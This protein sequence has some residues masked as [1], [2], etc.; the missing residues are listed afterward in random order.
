MRRSQDRPECTVIAG[1]NGSGKSTLARG[2]LPTL[3][4]WLP[5]LITINPDDIAHREFKNR[6]YEAVILRAAQQAEAMREDALR[7]G[8]HLLFET[9]FSAGD[10]LD[11]LRRAK[12][13]GYFVRLIFIAT[14]DPAVNSARVALRAAR[15]GHSVPLDRILSRYPKSIAQAALAL[16][17]VDRGHVFDNTQWWEAPDRIF[18]TVDGLVSRLGFSTMNGADCPWGWASALLDR[19]APHAFDPHGRPRDPQ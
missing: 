6:P 9:V 17:F 18:S 1:P 14:D 15:G 13:S 11:F 10:K 16:P 2:I 4:A 19:V 3:D 5:G 12:A 8:R 7:E